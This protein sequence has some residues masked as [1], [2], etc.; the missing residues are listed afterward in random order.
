MGNT[1]QTSWYQNKSLATLCLNN[2]ENYQVSSISFPEFINESVDL[3]TEFPVIWY[4][5]YKQTGFKIIGV[6]EV[7]SPR[8]VVQCQ[9]KKDIF[10]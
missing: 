2:F 9:I 6:L 7:A 3:Q 4:P 5:I 1:H 8:A 10:K